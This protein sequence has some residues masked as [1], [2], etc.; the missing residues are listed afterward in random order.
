MP[1]KKATE[2]KLMLKEL[3]DAVKRQGYENIQGIYDGLVEDGI[4]FHERLIWRWSSKAAPDMPPIQVVDWLL[5][6]SGWSKGK[7][8][9][10]HMVNLKSYLL[11]HTGG[12]LWEHAWD[13]LSPKVRKELVDIARE[14]VFTRTFLGKR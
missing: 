9:E 12:E 2:G 14:T 1:A 5:E 6:N 11:E 4:E 7:Q 3:L 8:Q 13:G 10:F